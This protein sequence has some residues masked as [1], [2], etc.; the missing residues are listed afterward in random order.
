[1][2]KTQEET[3]K[4]IMTAIAQDDRKFPALWT[5]ERRAGCD[6]LPGSIVDNVTSTFVVQMRSQLTGI[7]RHAPIE[8]HSVKVNDLFARHWGKIQVGLSV[9]GNF[10]PEVAGVGIGKTVLDNIARGT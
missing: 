9:L 4:A 3:T 8:I 10:I 5:L 1:M 7:C 6:H 2:N